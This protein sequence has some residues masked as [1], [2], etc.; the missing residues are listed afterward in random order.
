[1]RKVVLYIAKSLDGFIADEE[2]GVG[3]LRTEDGVKVQ[4]AGKN[5]QRL[6]IP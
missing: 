6:S 3:W 4:A 2:G 1:M 5:S